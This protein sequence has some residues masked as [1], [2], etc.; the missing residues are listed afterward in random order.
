MKTTGFWFFLIVLLIAVQPASAEIP[1]VAAFTSNMTSGMAPVTIQFIDASG[2]A[3]AS[4]TWTFGD[5]GSSTAQSP[6]HTYLVQ[7]TY[8][9]TLTV[10]NS[11]GSNTNTISNYITVNKAAPPI[12]SFTANR[13]SGTAPLMVNFTDTSTNTPSAWAWTFGDGGWTTT[14]NPSHVFT[15]PGIYPVSLTVTNNGGSNTYTVQNF[16]TVTKAPPPVVSFSANQT[17][18]AVPLS[19]NFTDASTNSPTGWS[20]SFGDGETSTLQNPVHTYTTTGSFAVSL[21]ATNYGGTVSQVKSNFIVVSPQTAPTASFTSNITHGPAPLSVN[22]SD[23]SSD[24][25]NTWTWVFGDGETSTLQNPVHTYT[26]AGSYTVSLTASNYG[27]NRTI[28]INNFTVVYPSMPIASFTSDQT[29]GSAP[30]TVSFSDTSSNSPTGWGWTFGDGTSSSRQNPSHTYSTPGTYSVSLVAINDGGSDLITRTGY[31]TVA[32]TTTLAPA[33]TIS[34]VSSPVMTATTVPVTTTQNGSAPS[35]SGIPSWALPI[36]V[37]LCIG[38]GLIYWIRNRPE[39]PGH[40]RQR[41]L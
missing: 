32:G 40:H 13:T 27:G 3:P 10:T 41:E 31:I 35:G 12:A 24:S 21:T 34:P 26:K 36:A 18:G 37:V 33:A 9:V 30:L 39:K 17:S 29:S 28:T 1:P 16:I 7:G 6:V 20:W 4:W 14:Q 2:N 25:P 38:A 11:A 22:F 23:A 5:G 19:V 8:T 15:A